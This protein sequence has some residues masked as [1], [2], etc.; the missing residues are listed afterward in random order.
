MLSKLAAASF[1]GYWYISSI[2]APL[3]ICYSYLIFY[4]CL[5]YLIGEGKFANH[6]IQA[7]AKGKLRILRN[8]FHRFMKRF[9]GMKQ[10]HIKNISKGK[11]ENI[12]GIF[13]RTYQ[14]YIFTLS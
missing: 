9:L 7:I 10:Y 11:T 13:S 1:I 4:G 5:V 14:K 6:V 2:S 12:P 3:R 8:S